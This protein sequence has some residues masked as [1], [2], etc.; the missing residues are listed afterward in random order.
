MKH[1]AE[2]DLELKIIGTIRSSIKTFDQAPKQGT[3]GGVDVWIDMEPFVERAMLR[4]K[5]G[6]TYLILTWLHKAD[7]G[8]LQVHPRGNRENPLTGVFATRSP[9]RPNPIGLHEVTL[10]DVETTP[11]RLHVAPMEAIDGT[12][13]VDIKSQFWPHK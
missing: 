3:E 8:C 9:S 1:E 5:P 6:E 13:V 11:L 10:L 2:I 12:P 4:L 7:R